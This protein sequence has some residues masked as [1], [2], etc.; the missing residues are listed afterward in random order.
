MSLLSA[1]VL[2]LML[3]S[4]P[5]RMCCL[6]QSSY[7]PRTLLF[8]T[9]HRCLF[10][11]HFHW[12]SKRRDFMILE[13]GMAHWSPFTTSDASLRK[14]EDWQRQLCSWLTYFDVF[15]KKKMHFLFF[16]CPLSELQLDFI[17]IIPRTSMAIIR[18]RPVQC[19]VVCDSCKSWVIQWIIQNHHLKLWK[20]V[21][22]MRNG[23]IS[24]ARID[25]RE[26][27]NWMVLSNPPSASPFR[28]HATQQ[29]G[30]DARRSHRWRAW[31]LSARHITFIRIQDQH[32]MM[33]PV[34]MGK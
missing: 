32:T 14:K 26:I 28:W 24:D 19:S 1:T 18:Q 30:I 22:D 15:G 9:Y 17:I 2:D 11:L 25:S 29:N 27:K 4:D 21:R 33:V 34:W 8:S 10:P 5:P 6:L 31:R 23:I 16:N 3:H 13:H 20:I 12:K 7:S